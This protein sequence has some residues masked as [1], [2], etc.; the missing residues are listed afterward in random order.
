[1]VKSFFL[2]SGLFIYAAFIISLL[3]YSGLFT[4]SKKR[5]DIFKCLL[6]INKISEISGT[7]CSSP[8]KL[9]KS[10]CYS[11]NF[12]VKSVTGKNNE[13]SS[14]Q[15][16][17]TLFL[18]EEDIEA[19]FPGKLFSAAK[20]NKAFIYDEGADICV[21]GKFFSKKEML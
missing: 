17:I 21:R 10:K 3:I 6:P 11:V 1:M 19:L 15:G 14:A 9:K 2:K 16:K 4:P 20:K 12:R 5:E 8:V 7:V 18:P 13:K